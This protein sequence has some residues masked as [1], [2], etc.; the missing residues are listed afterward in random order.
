[1]SKMSKDEVLAGLE[2]DM[3][4]PGAE[5]SGEYL[6]KHIIERSRRLLMTDRRGLVEALLEWL[7]LRSEPRTM[8]AV[9]VACELRL[10]ELRPEITILR[11]DIAMGRFFPGYYLRWVDDALDALG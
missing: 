8:L 2:T 9:R 5:K 4:D 10:S 3:D 7:S 11:E 6:R 1:M